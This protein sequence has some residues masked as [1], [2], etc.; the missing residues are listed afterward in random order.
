M[1]DRRVQI[2]APNLG[3]MRPCR[4]QQVGDDVID[5]RNFLPNVFHDRTRR[6]GR[7]QVSA[8]NLDDAGDPRQRVANFMRQPGRQFSQRG[9][10]LRTRHLRLMQALDLIAAFA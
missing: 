3:R 8:D 5:L 1:L 2:A 9:Q 4:L 7:R 10:M 6:A